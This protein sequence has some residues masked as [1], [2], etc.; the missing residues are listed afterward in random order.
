MLSLAR[1]TCFIQS[2]LI[3]FINKTNHPISG[4]S[5]HVLDVHDE[6]AFQEC[7]L[8]PRLLPHVAT[9]RRQKRLRQRHQES[10]LRLGP[11]PPDSLPQLLNI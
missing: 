8:A 3:I 7:R 1:P 6:L 2:R 9:H 10:G 11:L 4:E 5:L